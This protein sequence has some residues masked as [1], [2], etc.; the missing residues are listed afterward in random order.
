MIMRSE[1]AGPGIADGT[2]H[3]PRFPLVP[4]CSLGL[5]ALFAASLVLV[6]AGAGLLVAAAGLRDSP[7]AAN[8]A[9]TD[10]AATSQV[11]DAVSAD[12]SEIYSYSRTDIQATIAAAAR[13]LTG[14]AA[15]QYRQLSPMLANAVRQRL[16]VATRVVRAGVI[17]L[18]GDTARLL[19]FLDQTATRGDAKPTAVPAQLVVTARFSGGRWRIAS[20]EAR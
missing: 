12:V 14:Q 7:A 20:I 6:L 1:A 10:R 17:S 15:V 5:L 4:R 16:T 18:T 19:I 3:L 2:S 9:L 11:L 8:R 13:V